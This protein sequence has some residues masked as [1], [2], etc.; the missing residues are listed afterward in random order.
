[1]NVNVLS[2]ILFGLFALGSGNAPASTFGNVDT[3]GDMDLQDAILA[4][5]ICAGMRPSSNE[6]TQADV[7]DD[8]KIGLEEAIYALQ[9]IAQMRE[10]ARIWYKDADND[11]LSDGTTLISVNRPSEHY[12]E[13][14]ELFGTSS[15]PDDNN[16]EILVSL[17]S[18]L[19]V[20]QAFI[21]K[22][23]ADWVAGSNPAQ[24]LS[25]ICQTRREKICWVH[26][27]QM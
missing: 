25:Q 20:V 2:V 13:E 4:I 6:D 19:S 26:C 27:C 24:T 1:M 14:T 12:Y 23:D 16:P 21:E 7:N 5:Q 10:P 9:V 11:R 17:P 3:R 22:N 18:E 8:N 15:D